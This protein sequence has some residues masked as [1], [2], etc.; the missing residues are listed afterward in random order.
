MEKLVYYKG[1]Y[2]ADGTTA[3]I[4]VEE[5]TGEQYATVS[6]NLSGYG[7]KPQSENHI[8]IPSYNFTKEA[9][10]T[11]ILDLGKNVVREVQIGFGKGIELELKDNWKEICQDM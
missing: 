8:F 2:Q 11:F 6:V 3:I 4:A 7:M 5:S 9:L 1:K 10:D